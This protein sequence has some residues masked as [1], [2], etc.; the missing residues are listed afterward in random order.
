M[1]EKIYVV[2]IKNDQLNVSCKMKFA[3]EYSCFFLFL[4]NFLNVL[5][6]QINFIDSGV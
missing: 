2:V 5:N 4:I 3:P 1:S 6:L